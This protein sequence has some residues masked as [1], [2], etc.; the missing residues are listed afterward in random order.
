M[1]ILLV[2]I[3]H[4]KT[5]KLSSLSDDEDFE[6]NDMENDYKNLVIYPKHRVTLSS[7]H[8]QKKLVSGEY[9]YYCDCMVL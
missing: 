6:V 8:L 2:E 7:Q 4:D 3:P 1:R 9:S 5:D